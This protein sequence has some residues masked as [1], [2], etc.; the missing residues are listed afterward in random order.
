MRGTHLPD[1][2]S[3]SLGYFNLPKAT[4]ET[5]L[6]LWEDYSPGLHAEAM[7][8]AERVTAGVTGGVFWPPAEASRSDAYTGFAG[9]FHHGAADS[10]DSR[11]AEKARLR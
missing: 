4:G 5:G 3:L 2:P 8:C 7:R 1:S 6:E 11:F 9:L 10:V